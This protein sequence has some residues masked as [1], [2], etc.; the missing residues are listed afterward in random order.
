MQTEARVV[1]IGGGIAGCS[2]AY[3]LTRYGWKDIVLVDKGELT[4]GATWHAAGI[5]TVFHT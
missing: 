1:I 4:S 5:V 3:H 2:L